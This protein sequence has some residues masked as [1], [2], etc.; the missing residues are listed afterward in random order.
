MRCDATCNGNDR[1]LKT[2]TKKRYYC[3]LINGRVITKIVHSSDNGN[4]YLNQRN[5]CDYEAIQVDINDVY[6]VERYYR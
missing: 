3:L 6:L 4:F 2:R 5:G 1:Y